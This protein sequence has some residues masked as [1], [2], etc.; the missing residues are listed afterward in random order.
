MMMGSAVGAVPGNYC[1]TGYQYDSETNTT[2]IHVSIGC[3]AYPGLYPARRY[4]KTLM[5]GAVS[6][7]FSICFLPL[8]SPVT[9]ALAWEP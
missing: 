9:G 4:Y 1:A 7:Y 3:M 2:A 8:I 5:S 6:T